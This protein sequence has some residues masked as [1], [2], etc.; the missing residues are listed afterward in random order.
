MLGGARIT[1]K[2][3]PVLSF[4][5]GFGP[6]VVIEILIVNQEEKSF[7]VDSSANM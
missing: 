2:T 1:L 6:L 4:Q 3:H 7:S 5:L